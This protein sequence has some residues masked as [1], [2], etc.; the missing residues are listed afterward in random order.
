MPIYEYECKNC[1]TRFEKMQSITADPLTEC[2]NCGSGPI[3]R[4]MHPVGVIFKGS[5]WYITDNRKSSSSSSSESSSS[6]ASSTGSASSEKKSD[7]AG[8][9]APKDTSSSKETASSG[10]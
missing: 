6:S 1:N 9:S 7:T 4:V 2:L 8:S 5:G 10:E 3:R